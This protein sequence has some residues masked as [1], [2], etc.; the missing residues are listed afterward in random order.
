MSPGKRREI[1]CWTRRVKIG[2][3]VM[4]TENKSPVLLAIGI[5]QSVPKMHEGVY[6]STY[7]EVQ[8]LHVMLH[9]NYP[10]PE[11]APMHRIGKYKGSALRVLQEV[12]GE[13]LM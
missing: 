6:F 1:I 11:T 9:K 4:L 7:R 8:W 13:K 3:L 10:L 5:V 2:D 12:M